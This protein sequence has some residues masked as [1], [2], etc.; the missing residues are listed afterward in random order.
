MNRVRE[1]RRS[2]S[3]T[4]EELARR[5]GVTTSTIQKLEAGRFEP[6]LLTARRIARAL[7][8]SLADLFEE[9]AA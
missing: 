3:I 9:P 6:R 5:S 8:S 4:Q 2:Q 7:G 1:V